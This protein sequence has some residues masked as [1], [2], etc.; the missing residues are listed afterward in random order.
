MAHARPSAEPSAL[1]KAQLLGETAH[2]GEVFAPW[3]GLVQDVEIF[4]TE[5]DA[6]KAIRAAREPDA[7]HYVRA[8]GAVL[9]LDAV[10]TGDHAFAATTVGRIGRALTAHAEMAAQQALR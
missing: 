8:R 10:L 2:D 7:A 3:V 1:A 6:A 4:V 5:P 9:A